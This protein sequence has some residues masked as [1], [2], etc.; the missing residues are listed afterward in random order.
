MMRSLYIGSAV[1]CLIISITILTGCAVTKESR[2]YTLNTVNSQAADKPY[3]ESNER[4]LIALGPIEI[5]DVLD[6][7]QMVIYSGVN[8]LLFSEFDRW[9]GSLKDIISDVVMEDISGLL[10]SDGMALVSWRQPVPATY[11]IDLQITKFG[12][13]SENEIVLSARWTLS[14][15]ESK[16]VVYT[17]ESNLNEPTEGQG[18]SAAAESMSR[19][20]QTLSRE[21]AD[22]IREIA[23][24]ES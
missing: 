13:I 11:R 3:I 7:P 12:R 10:A 6:R 16:K 9:A 24:D 2:F 17:S 4:V 14:D 8:E 18:H 5:P 21:I 23:A 19:A 22:V 15:G 20:L 1:L